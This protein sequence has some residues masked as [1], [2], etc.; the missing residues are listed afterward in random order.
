MTK[1][2]ANRWLYKIY[3]MLKTDTTMKLRLNRKLG[4]LYGM[5]T[6]Y[7]AGRTAALVEVNPAKKEF[8]STIVHECLHLVDWDMPEKNVRELEYDLME[9]LTDRQL[10][11]LLKRVILFHTKEGRR[12]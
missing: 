1:A 4:K 3:N 10:L 11:N 7:A 9:Q 8:M 6:I 5:T 2:Q 12:G